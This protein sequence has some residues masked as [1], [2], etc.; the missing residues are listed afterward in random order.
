MWEASSLEVGS[1]RYS[2]INYHASFPLFFSP[3]LKTKQNKTQTQNHG[4]SATV[5]ENAVLLV[6]YELIVNFIK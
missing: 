1:V 2:K 6:N 4:I 3:F 5:H